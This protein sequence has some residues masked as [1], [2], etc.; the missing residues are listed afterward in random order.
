MDLSA[1][2]ANMGTSVLAGLLTAGIIG[3]VLELVQLPLGTAI[4]AFAGGVV[5]A[6]LVHAQRARAIVAGFIVGLL[7]FPI[8]LLL[9]SVIMITGFYTPPEVPPISE[10]ELLI[11]LAATVI[12]QVV[13]GAIGGLLGGVL[14]HPSAPVV[15]VARPSIPPPPPRPEKYCVQCGAGLAKET[16]I[17]PA[18][19][20]KQAQ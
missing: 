17:C 1:K 20:A 18:C 12:I 7:S 10:N 11:A 13:A 8:Q 2:K 15:E 5:A 3:I 19:G 9:F 6:L 4:G 14:R 16:P